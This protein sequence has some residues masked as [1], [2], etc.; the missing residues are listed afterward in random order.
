MAE[1]QQDQ[2]AGKDFKRNVILEL[3]AEKYYWMGVETWTITE[4]GETKT[5]KPSLV[6]RELKKDKNG[7]MRTG[8]CKGLTLED[9]QLIFKE[10]EKVKPA[11]MQT[12]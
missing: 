10:K 9:L 7:N 12:S 8:H 5:T 3:K 6:K 11:L 2:G 1:Q 4:N